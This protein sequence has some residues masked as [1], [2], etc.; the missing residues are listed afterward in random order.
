M[1]GEEG[2]RKAYESILNGDY[3]QAVAWFKRAIEAEPDN[4]DYHYRLSI[5]YA[6]S[7]RLD[8][9]IE[10]GMRAVRLAP[11]EQLY[12]FHLGHL[13]ARDLICQAETLIGQEGTQLYLAVALLKEAISLDPLSVEAHLLLGLAYGGLQEYALGIQAFKEALRLDP[14]NV[15]AADLLKDY[16]MRWNEFMNAK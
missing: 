2:I 3:E 14:H 1:N 12:A 9:A 5:T 15:T 8:K 10:H 13:K 4:A 6:R 11:D 7:N 16:S